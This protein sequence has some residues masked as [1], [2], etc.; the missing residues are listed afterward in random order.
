MT[1]ILPQNYHAKKA[2]EKNR[3][4]CITADKAFKA[5]IRPLRI[6]IL[7]IMPE[8][9][10]YEF[11]LL[12]PLGRSILQIIPV[13]IKLHSHQYQSTSKPHL[14]KLYVYF[15]DAIKKAPIDGM[16][17]TGA[18]VEKLKFKQIKYWQELKD[19][20]KYCYAKVPSTLGIC[21]GAMALAFFL[22][23]E[24]EN[25]NTK[26]FGVYETENLDKNHR[27]TGSLD[28]VFWLPQSRFAGHLNEVL[29]AAAKANIVK[30]LAKTIG[31]DYPIF[32]STNGKFLMNL[33]HFEYDTE[34]IITEFNRDKLK[35]I[36]NYPQN[37][38]I[39]KPLNRWRGQRNEFY[40]QWLKFCHEE[41][42]KINNYNDTYNQKS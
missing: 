15:E 22:D 13:W 27:I 14:D 20:F 8:A 33:G 10:D 23:I 42:H 3:V 17:I 4:I 18:P 5:D 38:D 6:A 34:R 16:I 7:N 21:W 37:F 19:I 36:I 25:Y 2:L 9:Q 28:D 40:H 35:G 39:N 24:K 29:Q 30:L 11:S 41:T 31:F 32:E 12:H 1:I 26:H